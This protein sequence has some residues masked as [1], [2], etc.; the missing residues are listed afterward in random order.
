MRCAS[1][2]WAAA[3]RRDPSRP[4]L[5]RELGVA[6]ALLFAYDR[7]AGLAALRAFPAQMHARQLLNLEA[8]L[9]IAIEGPLNSGLVHLSALRTPFSA[10]Y[11]LAHGTVTFGMLALLYLRFPAQ[12]RAR[13]RAL[14]AVN[15][16]ALLIFFAWPAA[17]PRLSSSLRLVDVVAASH[18]WGAWPAST[19]TPHADQF[20][21]MPSLHIAWATWVLLSVLAATERRLPRYLAVAHLA[22]TAVVVLTTANH[23]VVDGVAGAVL[24]LVLTAATSEA[25]WVHLRRA[26][27]GRSVCGSRASSAVWGRGITN[28]TDAADPTRG[29]AP[30]M[31]AEHRS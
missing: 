26:Q 13:R 2:A 1:A 6:L 12:Y 16:V 9:H 22:T 19:A 10:Y 4:R 5:V 17:P 20:A 29:P 23:F 14:L 25:T 8:A 7:I 18:V 24:C 31:R 3:A 27:A 21:A 28:Q 30:P 11:T 15:A